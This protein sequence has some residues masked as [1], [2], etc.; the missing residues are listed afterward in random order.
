[1]TTEGAVAAG[2]PGAGQVL[3]AQ[4]DAA[5]TPLTTSE[6]MASA[7]DHGTSLGGSQPGILSVKK[8]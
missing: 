7:A 6:P 5:A 2:R 1:M 3:A 4:M 8:C